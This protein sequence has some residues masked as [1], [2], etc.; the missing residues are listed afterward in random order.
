VS[1][2]L[3]SKLELPVIVNFCNLQYSP[4]ETL[5]EFGFGCKFNNNNQ[6]IRFYYQVITVVRNTTTT[7]VGLS[8]F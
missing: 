6:R 5:V 2:T 1:E 3:I 4:T 8:I 7:K